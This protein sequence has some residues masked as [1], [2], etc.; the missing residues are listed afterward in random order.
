MLRKFLL[1]GVLAGLFATPMMASARW[2]VAGRNTQNSDVII[3]QSGWSYR[4]LK[5]EYKIYTVWY[6]SDPNAK[7]GWKADMMINATG[8]DKEYCRFY[9]NGGWGEFEEKWWGKDI[10]V[11]FYGDGLG[12]WISFKAHSEYGGYCAEVSSEHF[13]K[14]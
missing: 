3:I 11:L 8:G 4:I 2:I 14:H 7:Y 6:N 9:S 10:T 5:A 12:D 1:I 13:K